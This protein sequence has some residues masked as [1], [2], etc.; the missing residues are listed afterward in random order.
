VKVGIAALSQQA[1]ITPRRQP[2]L[3]RH[4]LWNYSKCSDNRNLPSCFCLAPCAIKNGVRGYQRY[5]LV[6]AVYQLQNAAKRFLRMHPG[7]FP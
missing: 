6:F 2:V 1:R 3:F 5:A 7:N 4:H